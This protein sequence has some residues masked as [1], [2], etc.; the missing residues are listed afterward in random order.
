MLY[1]AIRRKGKDRKGLIVVYI[2]T[3]FIPLIPTIGKVYQ[4]VK[5][6]DDYFYQIALLTILYILLIIIELTVLAVVDFIH[7]KV[8]ASVIIGL[9]L[10]WPGIIFF[11]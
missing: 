9:F 7:R 1:V 6:T 11:C 2:T 3:A 10:V 8:K 4:T 5:H